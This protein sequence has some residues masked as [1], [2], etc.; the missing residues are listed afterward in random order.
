[1]SRLF[2]SLGSLAGSLKY[3]AMSRLTSGWAVTVESSD[4]AS[5]RKDSFAFAEAANVNGKIEDCSS[6]TASAR[7]KRDLLN[8][9]LAHF[10]GKLSR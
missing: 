4:H 3:G 2:G 5:R 7:A 1:M 8:G 6:E 10:V 9:F